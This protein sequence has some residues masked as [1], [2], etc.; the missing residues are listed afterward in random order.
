[1][2]VPMPDSAVQIAKWVNLFWPGV[3]AKLILRDNEPNRDCITWYD[4]AMITANE[5]KKPIPKIG[6][7]TT[8]I[9]PAGPISSADYIVTGLTNSYGGDYQATLILE[10]AESRELVKSVSV[11]FKNEPQSVTNSSTELASKFGSILNVIKD[12]ER[13]KRNTDNTVAI[14]DLWKSDSPEEIKLTPAKR[15]IETEEPVDIKVEMID[16]DGV[17]LGNRKIYF[18]DTTISGMNFTGTKGGKIEPPVVVT[19]AGGEATVK[20]TAGTTPG[21]V[22]ITAFYPHKK[23]CGRDGGFSGAAAVM[24]G[25]APAK[26]WVVQATISEQTIRTIDTTWTGNNQEGI[27][28]VYEK[29]EG[30]AFITGLAESGSGPDSTFYASYYESF[31]YPMENLSVSGNG[32]VDNYNRYILR[33]QDPLPQTDIGSSHY[34]GV[35]EEGSTDFEFHY[36]AKSGD[37]VIAAQCNGSAKGGY[38]WAHSVYSPESKIVRESGYNTTSFSVAVDFSHGECSVT[39]TD[40]SYTITGSKTTQQVHHILGTGP[41][42]T[43][44]KMSI[45]A[46]ITAKGTVTKVT[47]GESKVPSVFSLKQNYPNPFN[48][49]TT[50]KFSLPQAGHY[51]MKVYDLL[52]KEVAVL[53]NGELKEGNYNINFNA[54]NLSTGVYIY[55]LHGSSVSMTRK[56]LLLK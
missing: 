27:S 18:V 56:M 6:P 29:R 44:Q 25:R 2:L 38:T 24:I 10:T 52:G 45:K 28:S 13:N 14:R 7:G 43:T 53:I 20:F 3:S 37:V 55:H 9:P 51:T 41:E 34:R 15:N 42:I 22:Q 54:E 26:K 36:P 8:N 4:G 46:V 21:L 47:G 50:I 17:P 30:R 5:L 39:R 35:V 32:S 33:W 12:F 19:D 16:C 31:G 40:S 48:P 11:I 23:P 1:M 49:S